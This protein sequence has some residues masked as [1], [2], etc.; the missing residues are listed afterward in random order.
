MIITASR[1]N[2]LL[3]IPTLSTYVIIL[4]WLAATQIEQKRLRNPGKLQL[5]VP[6]YVIPI[7]KIPF[8]LAIFNRFK[9]AVFS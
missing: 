2:Q 4:A 9:S 3:K 1:K 5:L 8:I 7:T 6:V